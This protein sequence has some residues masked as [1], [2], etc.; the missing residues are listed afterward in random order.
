MS[1]TKFLA[2]SGIVYL[3]LTAMEWFVHRYVMHAYDRPK[4]PILGRVI[5]KESDSHWEHHRSVRSDMSLDLES[6]TNVHAGLFFHYNVAFMFT[7]IL[8]VLLSIQFKVFKLEMKPRN[9]I[10]LSFFIT[11]SYSFLWNCTH[12]RLHNEHDIIISGYDGVTNRYQ[13]VVVNFIP[14]VWFDWMMVNHSM[15]HAVKGKSKGN[16]NIILPGF[17]HLMGTYHSNCFDNT[18]FC[19]NSDLTSC[20]KPKGCFDVNGTKLHVTFD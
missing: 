5:Q 7:I 9:V 8:G 20:D 19:K 2:T 15:H 11:M 13:D 6:K 17:D 10:L 16:Y 18:E 1:L 4:I 3:N 14:K 12:A